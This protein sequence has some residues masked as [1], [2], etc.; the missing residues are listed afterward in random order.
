MAPR[1][2]GGSVRLSSLVVRS[3]VDRRT[4]V[5]EP[6]R[7]INVGGG[8]VVEGIVVL[9]VCQLEELDGG[10]YFCDGVEV[11][12]LLKVVGPGAIG[13]KE[14]SGRYGADELGHT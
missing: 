10:H 14:G 12:G 4:S 13:F 5:R 11:V 1:T 8:G 2:L 9:Y 6:E 3:V 7:K